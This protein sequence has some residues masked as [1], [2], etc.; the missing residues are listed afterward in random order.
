MKFFVEVSEFL[1]HSALYVEFRVVEGLD[2]HLITLAL[3]WS[4]TDLQTL[5]FMSFESCRKDDHRSIWF[6][7][8]SFIQTGLCSK[9][10]VQTSKT[11][12]ISLIMHS[13]SRS[14]GD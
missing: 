7:P 11:F 5:W 14:T 10:D 3:G 13:G 8:N 4:P 12:E 1:W 6:D 9:S 2:P